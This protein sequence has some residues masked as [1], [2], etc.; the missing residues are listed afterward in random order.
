MIKTLGTLLAV[1]A[2]GAFMLLGGSARA[3]VPQLI[4][5]QG[6]VTVEGVNFTGTGQFKFA[7]VDGAG[8]TTFWS[9]DGTSSNAAEPASSVSLNVTN[10]LY[11][12]LLGN[13]AIP[14][15]VGI[16]PAVFNNADVRLRVWFDDGVHG[17]QLLTPDERIAAVGYAMK[18]AFASTV[19]DGAVTADKIAAGAAAASLNSSGQGIVPTGGLVLSLNENPALVGAGYI[20]IGTATLNGFTAYTWQQAPAP[21]GGSPPSARSLH[22]AVWTG[23]EMIIWGGSTTGLLNGEVNSGARY[24][25]TTNTWTPL[26]TVNAPAARILHSAVWTGSELIIWGGDSSS[27]KFNSGARYNAATNTWTPMS[28]TGA[29]VARHSH[30]AVWTGAVM[31]IW[32]GESDAGLQNDGAI[33][34]PNTDIWTPVSMTDSPSVRARHTAVWTGSEMVVWGGDAPVGQLD[35]GGRYNPGTDTWLA[36]PALGAPAPRANHSAVWNGSQMIVWGGWGGVFRSD[37]ARL[38]PAT[39]SWAAMTTGSAPPGRFKHSATWTDN[40]MIIFGGYGG[41]E[42][43]TAAHYDATANVWASAVAANAPSARENHSAVWTGNKLII[44]GGYSGAGGGTTFNDMWFLSFGP[45]AMHLYQR[46]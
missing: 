1:L 12:V 15:M 31:I 21:A 10:G 41:Q 9:N 19:S 26:P 4:N 3:E 33:Y 36:T 2:L 37:G 30:T 20:R 8:T 35:T 32:G 43:N 22:S 46:P 24:N 42:F 17:F 11:S 23:T 38:N 39:D 7:L 40:R 14:G 27:A 16:P 44:W 18:A 29:P 45:Q 6:R 5:Y 25:P 13:T 28:T 34:D